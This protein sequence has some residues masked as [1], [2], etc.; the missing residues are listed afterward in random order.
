[1]GLLPCGMVYA[2]LLVTS[3]LASPL[4][5]AL[6]MV[7]FGA[8]T[9]PALSAVVLGSRAAPAWLRARG[10][11]IAAGLL[12]AMGVFMLARALLVTPG[13]AMAHASPP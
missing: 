6:G 8:G 9:L 1:M 5:S 12:V 2:M 13:A 3:T 10:T 11:R 7:C 4:H